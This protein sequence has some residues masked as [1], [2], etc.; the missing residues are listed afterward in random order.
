MVKIN[1]KFF[2][3]HFFFLIPI[4]VNKNKEVTSLTIHTPTSINY[5]IRMNTDSRHQDES[6]RKSDEPSIKLRAKNNEL[7][8]SINIMEASLTNNNTAKTQIK[9]ET[10]KKQ[11]NRN[12]NSILDEKIE[13]IEKTANFDLSSN[14]SETESSYDNRKSNK[15]SITIKKVKT[16]QSSHKKYDHVQIDSTNTAK[17]TN[18]YTSNNN[19]IL[20]VNNTNQ[21]TSKKSNK[22]VDIHLLE[23]PKTSEHEKDKEREK[24]RDK[25]R[26]RE[27]T[28]VKV[29]VIHTTHSVS[30]NT[31]TRPTSNIIEHI[32]NEK[33]K[34]RMIKKHSSDKEKS[35]TSTASEKSKIVIKKPSSLEEAKYHAELNLKRFNGIVANCIDPKLIAKTMER[36]L[37]LTER[38]KT[39]VPMDTTS[40]QNSAFLRKIS[41]PPPLPNI[42]DKLDLLNSPKMMSNFTNHH[43][44]N[45]NNNNNHHHHHHHHHNHNH[46]HH[47]NN[48]HDKNL[49]HEIKIINSNLEA[50]N[51]L[52]T[53]TRPVSITSSIRSGK[54]EKPLRLNHGLPPPPALNLKQ[55]IQSLKYN[56][57]QSTQPTSQ[58]SKKSSDLNN[59]KILPLTSNLISKLKLTDSTTNK[60]ST[61]ESDTHKE[62]KHRISDISEDSKRE[63]PKTQQQV[64]IKKTTE[65]P[66]STTTTTT[67]TTTNTTTTT[68]SNKKTED[69]Q[70]PKTNVKTL[71]LNGMTTNIPV[72]ENFGGRCTNLPQLG[73]ID[74]IYKTSDDRY[75]PLKNLNY[76]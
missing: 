23:K 76:S 30:S 48:Y 61:T 46:N 33:N 7:T 22:I 6:S 47:H 66:V 59:K 39:T 50:K 25:E 5:N 73:A 54:S 14:E 24:I 11:S 63:K 29:P 70:K 17:I 10:N 4:L 15:K 9:N 55:E 51:N 27:R 75:K 44:T 60:K 32:E 69:E 62:T 21:K 57:T 18:N 74:Y 45:N 12:S 40:G 65:K 13:E 31:T 19:N 2:L 3:F 56:L 20:I 72:D 36:S 28:R 26:E 38:P 34:S 8:A 49:D 41:T 43:S 16:E 42:L 1:L 67:T 64:T 52:P 71:V 68:Q 58:S 35:Q 37:F 53:S